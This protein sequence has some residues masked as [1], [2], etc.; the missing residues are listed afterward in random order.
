MKHSRPGK[1]VSVTWWPAS[2]G[3]A[4]AER[5]VSVGQMEPRDPRN[6]RRVPMRCQ[7]SAEQ[8]PQFD[9]KQK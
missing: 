5:E 3:N 8:S 7:Q 4:V 6:F 2:A 9:M 1:K